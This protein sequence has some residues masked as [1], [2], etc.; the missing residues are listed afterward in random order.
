M[1]KKKT[2]RWEFDHVCPFC[3]LHYD[4]LNGPN[5]PGVALLQPGSPAEAAVAALGTEVM[6][7]EQLCTACQKE[8]GGR[9]VVIIQALKRSQIIIEN[10]E[11]RAVT[12]YILSRAKTEKRY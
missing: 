1:A 2:T 6:I 3:K 8:T 5:V 11:P 4:G 7:F 9:Y 12:Q 10:D